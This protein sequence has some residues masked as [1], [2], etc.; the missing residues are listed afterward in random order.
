A[1][2]GVAVPSEPNPLPRL[3]YGPEAERGILHEPP[4]PTGDRYPVFVPT[5]DDDGNEVAGVR[6]PMVAVP[7]ATHTGWNLRARGHGHGVQ[8]RFEGSTIPFPDTT[9]ERIATGDPRPAILER[10]EDKAA[11]VAAIVTAA[12]F[13]VTQRLLLEEDVARAAE[14]AADWGRPRHEVHL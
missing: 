2:P 13:L 6:V 5:V 1:I 9:S 14:A 11:Y 3:D 10:Y 8:W 4:V 12:R 7:L